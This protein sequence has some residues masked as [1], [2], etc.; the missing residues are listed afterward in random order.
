MKQKQNHEMPH[1]CNREQKHSIMLAEALAR[2]GV[3]EVMEVYGQWQEQDQGLDPYRTAT[4]EPFQ[5]KSTNH[6]N[7]R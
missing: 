3:R 7:A 2:P 6:A 4:K 1:A 5:I